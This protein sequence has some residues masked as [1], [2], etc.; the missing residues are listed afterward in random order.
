SSLY[1]WINELS[2]SISKED[3]NS[4]YDL[5]YISEKWNGLFPD[6]AVLTK[7]GK[8]V[9][10][11]IL[12]TKVANKEEI[13]TFFRELYDVY[14]KYFGTSKFDC[15]G[16]KPSM[17]LDGK[18]IEG[19]LGYANYYYESINGN[20]ELHNEIIEKVKRACELN[21]PNNQTK[22]VPEIHCTLANFIIHSKW[23]DIDAQISTR[24]DEYFS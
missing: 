18:F 6:S 14:P 2:N 7:K 5:G 8:K 16:L 13:I 9:L 12:E 15:K 22:Q 17:T 23:K 24:S 3:V 21:A 11:L 10:S 4:L 20:R 19:P 1:E